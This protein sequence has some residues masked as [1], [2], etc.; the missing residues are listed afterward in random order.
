M[1]TAGWSGY[2]FAGFLELCLAVF[3]I[4]GMLAP[5]WPRSLPFMP[6]ILALWC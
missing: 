4:A 5:S 6:R 2:N 1:E 3:V